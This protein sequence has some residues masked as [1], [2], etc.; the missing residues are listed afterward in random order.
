[1]SERLLSL[2]WKVRLALLREA[3]C[4][5]VVGGSTALRVVSQIE[6][7]LIVAPLP[8]HA[9]ETTGLEGCRLLAHHGIFC[10]VIVVYISL[11]AVVLHCDVVVFKRDVNVEDHH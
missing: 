2:P 11:V 8:C 3:T 4:A 6:V 9:L 7:C 10:S 5:A 1:M